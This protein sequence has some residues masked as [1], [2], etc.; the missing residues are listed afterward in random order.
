MLRAPR[1]VRNLN[2]IFLS[3]KP[4]NPRH[5]AAGADMLIRTDQQPSS[6]FVSG[7]RV[8]PAASNR[9]GGAGA[10]KCNWVVCNSS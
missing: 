5:I 4:L 8:G 6:D 3:T 2:A 1:V 9:H 10:G 7:L